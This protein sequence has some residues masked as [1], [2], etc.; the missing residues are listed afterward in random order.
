MKK[1]GGN[2]T[3]LPPQPVSSPA[4]KVLQKAGP[5][6]PEHDI[7]VIDGTTQL[8]LKRSGT[9]AAA[10]AA[11]AASSSSKAAVPYRGFFSPLSL[12]APTPAALRPALP[13]SPP[14]QYPLPVAG[15]LR[16]SAFAEATGKESIFER[17]HKCEGN[18]CGERGKGGTRLWAAGVGG[19]SWKGVDST[20]DK[21]FVD[22]V[23]GSD[24]GQQSV[25]RVTASD[26]HDAARGGAAA[27]DG[28]VARLLGQLEGKEGRAV[29]Q[30]EN[31]CAGAAAVSAAVVE[32]C[33]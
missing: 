19:V 25:S 23:G 2:P 7:Q 12:A 1:D 30:G 33:R 27:W 20:S 6:L 8:T 9:A 13:H 22:F 11:N 21:T 10:A 24:A 18:G 32:A 29:L 15:E 31:A 26:V 14:P 4:A 17:G 28:V 16:G 3:K 5:S